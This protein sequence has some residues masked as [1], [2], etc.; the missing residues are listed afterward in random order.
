M[1]VSSTSVLKSTSH[2]RNTDTKLFSVRVTQEYH[3][4]LSVSVRPHRLLF[5]LMAAKDKLFRIYYMRSDDCADAHPIVSFKMS[6][7]MTL[8]TIYRA[9]T[10]S[11]TNTRLNEHFPLIYARG[12]I[13]CSAVC[14]KQ[15]TKCA[16]LEAMG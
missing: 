15:V 6:F 11:D 8:R 2:L 1:N 14:C 7:E 3:F 9:I 13:K 5:E 16:L 10:V 4:P 12:L